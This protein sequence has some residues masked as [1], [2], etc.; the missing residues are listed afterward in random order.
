MEPVLHVRN[1]FEFTVHAP[2]KAVFPLFGADR[3]RVW[4]SD[5]W[6]PQFL[7]PTPAGD[8]ALDVPG[9]VFRVSHGQHH[10]AW[11][12]TAFDPDHGHVQYVY[13]IPDALVT[14]IDIHLTQPDSSTTKVSVAY[15]RT[16]LNV[17]S[18]YHV[19]QLGE[20]DR[21]Y[22]KTWEEDIQ[23]YLAKQPTS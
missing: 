21:G 7:Y 6:N 9:S 16:A 17:L 19:R 20:A 23:R 3:E 12:N 18:N 1:E 10:A 8:I 11:V 4:A 14:L 5:D 13:F 22:G 2:Y 15:E